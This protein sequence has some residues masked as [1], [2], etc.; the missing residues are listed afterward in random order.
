MIVLDISGSMNVYA[1]SSK[2]RIQII[3][4]TLNGHDGKAGLLDTFSFVDYISIVLF[5][6]EANV[7]SISDEYSSDLYL[8]QATTQNI[9][10]AKTAVNGIAANGQTNFRAGFKKDF[11]VLQ[12]S[13]KTEGHT[14]SCSSVILFLTD[15]KDGD[16][17]TCDSY[18]DSYGACKC[19]ENMLSQIDEMQSQL[20]TAGGKRATV[21]TYSMGEF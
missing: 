2:S 15:G 7:L 1:Q 3:K 19:T 8:V 9:A 14:S 17:E 10:K 18:R 12:T 11:E 16:C 4:E 6:G 13:A 21:F 5:N 20:E